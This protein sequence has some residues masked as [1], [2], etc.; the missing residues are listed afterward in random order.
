MFLTLFIVLAISS[1]WFS[2]KKPSIAFALMLCTFSIEQWFQSKDVFF[3]SHGSLINFT[4]GFIIIVSLLLRLFNNFRYQEMFTQTSWFV[5]ALYIY[6][7]ASVLWSPVSDIAIDNFLHAIPYIV[8]SVL[9][10]PLLISNKEDAYDA[11]KYL[12]IFGSIIV[13]CL[14]FFADWGYRRILMAGLVGDARANPLAIANMAGYVLFASILFNFKKEF[15]YWNVLKWLVVLLCLGIAVKTG[16]RGQFLLMIFLSM[17]LLPLSRPINQLKKILPVM[18]GFLVILVGSYWAMDTFTSDYN[19]VENARWDADRMGDDVAGR[20]DAASNL[21]N[22]WYDS[23]ANVLFGLGSSAS[24]D[25]AIAGFYT[26]IVPLEILG[27]LGIIGFTLFLF[28]LYM[29]FKAFRRSIVHTKG[30]LTARGILATFSAIALFEFLLSFK[31]G[32]FLGSQFLFCMLVVLPKLEKSFEQSV[33]STD[34]QER[35]TLQNELPNKFTY[36]GVKLK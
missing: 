6:T 26:H 5:F 28:I 29:V 3:L 18:F 17:F 10:S 30:D 1:L 23:P 27:E 8:L 19:Q 22:T 12:V 34:I 4:I 33:K 2:Y 13:V 25:P 24:Y 35:D 11:G 15:K 32:S 14:L 36:I 16:S 20:F 7:S 31:Q 21:I 9:I